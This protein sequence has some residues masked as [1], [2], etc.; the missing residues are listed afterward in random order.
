MP[1]SN[2]TVKAI[3]E[4]IPVEPEE[5]G[6]EDG[7]GTGGEDGGETGSGSGTVTVINEE[8]G[9]DA[10]KGGDNDNDTGDFWERVRQAINDAAPGQTVRAEARGEE[11]MP[12]AVMSDP[13]QAEDVSPCTSPGTAARTSSSPPGRRWSPRRTGRSTS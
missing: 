9:S 11:R 4:P 3:F 13:G 6:G 2:V 7:G 10:G 5:P 8:S 12:V 1:A